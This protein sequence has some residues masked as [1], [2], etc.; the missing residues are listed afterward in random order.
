MAYIDDI[1][2]HSP[3]WEQHL[4]DLERTFKKLRDAGLTVKKRKC[5]F[6]GATVSFLGHIVGKGEVRPQEAKVEAI[7]SY[8]MPKTKK[9]LRA[10]LGLVGYYRKFIPRFSS[11]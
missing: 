2:I 5:H 8:Q 11:T 6:A 4:E 10:F 1:V 9:D 7:Q 3:T